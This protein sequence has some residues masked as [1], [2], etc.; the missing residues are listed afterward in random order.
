M[1][2][3]EMFIVW[4]DVKPDITHFAIYQ[5]YQDSYNSKIT[6]KIQI[7]TILVKNNIVPR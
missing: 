6:I 5:Y 4:A 2:T 3:Y 7:G 1:R